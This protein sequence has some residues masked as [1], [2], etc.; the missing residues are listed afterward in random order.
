MHPN[1]TQN[2]Q[3]RSIHAACAALSRRLYDSPRSL[4]V[5]PSLRVVHRQN[6]ER[7]TQCISNHQKLGLPLT[8]GGGFAL[9][10]AHHEAFQVL[11]VNCDDPVR[12][13]RQPPAKCSATPFCQGLRI[14]VRTTLTFIELIAAGTSKR[15]F[16]S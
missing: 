12:S 14:A 11:L 9:A 5:Q 10:V 13:R 6:S 7:T 4:Q 1:A 16:A 8:W 15:Y 3:N 2:S